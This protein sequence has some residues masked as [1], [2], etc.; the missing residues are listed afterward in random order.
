MLRSLLSTPLSQLHITSPHK[1]TSNILIENFRDRTPGFMTAT[2]VSCLWFIIH[3]ILADTHPQ[4]L[5]L[6]LLP[7]AIGAPTNTMTDV[8]P[9]DDNRELSSAQIGAIVGVVVAIGIMYWI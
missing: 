8:V 4:L 2:L 1:F 9:R 6:R 3:L 5:I 7:F